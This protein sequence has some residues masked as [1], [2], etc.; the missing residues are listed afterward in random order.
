MP[1]SSQ[2][3]PSAGPAREALRQKGQ[4]WT[5]DWVAEAMVAYAVRGGSD[6]V[7]DPA[8]GAGAFFRAAKTVA[9]ETGRSFTLL[10]AEID[11]EALGQAKQN[12]L[13]EGDLARVHISDFALHPPQQAFK[14]IVANPPYIR[15]HR[16]SAT[17]KLELKKFGARLIGTPLDGR[18]GLHVYFLM[19]ALQLL[20]KGG[21]LAFIMPA[22]TCEGIFSSTLWE[23]IT[24]NYCLDAVVTFAPEASPFPRVD[25]NPIIFLIR[26]S[27]PSAHFQWAK[28]FEPETE[29]L[30]TW[31]ASDFTFAG[32]A[33]RVVQRQL[34]EGLATGLSRE[35]LDE[36]NTGPI[37]A[38]FA[39]VMRGIATGANEFFFLTVQQVTKLNI[40]DEFLIPAVGRTRDVDGD[41]FDIE[42]LDELNARGRP[43]R[44]FSLDGRPVDC[45]PLAVREYLKH[46]EALGLH[47]RTLI[48]TRR[49]WYKMEVRP[50]PPILFSYLGR[51]HARFIR[52]S[53]GVVPL[54]GFLCV[55]PRQHDS[56]FISRL[57]EVLRHPET[58][59]NLGLVGKSYGS[60]AIKVEPRALERLPL[61]MCAIAC[62]GLCDEMSATPRHVEQRVVQPFLPL[63]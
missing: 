37:L 6:H 54:T 33:L 51:R 27:E 12:G 60:G 23:W 42:D 39:K 45:F 24:S 16:L 52:N 59:A 46:G 25:T 58:I 20:E 49:P 13:S 15:H 2:K 41:K 4:F 29:Q 11:R 17:V 38:D 56:I 53:A 44:L 18:A 55:Y 14:A 47:E 30:K 10:G 26:N 21:R 43:T 31:M 36:Q 5:P 62:S 40:P 22:D 7:F 34:R 61:S 32:D 3:L 8:V 9:K 50:A 1:D 48:A 35:P 57:W 63:S 19:R 28:C